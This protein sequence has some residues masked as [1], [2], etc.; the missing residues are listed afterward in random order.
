[1]IPFQCSG[2][3][4]GLQVKDE[5]RGQKVKC[6]GCGRVLRVPEALAAPS[7][8]PEAR[9]AEW[10]TRGGSQA[11]PA[12]LAPESATPATFPPGDGPAPF[13]TSGPGVTRNEEGQDKPAELVEFLAPPQAPDEIG[14][15]GPY[16]VLKVLGAGG[17]GV[18]YKAEDPQLQR[19]VALKA[20]LPSLAVSESARQRFLREARAVAAIK[21]DHIV[22]IY[23]VGQDRG[24]P[25]L[26]MEYLDGEPLDE[27]LQRAPPLAP[28]EVLRIGREAAAGLA[29]AHQRGLVHRDIKPANLWLEAPGGRVK[30]LDF[31]LARAA[32]DN[33]QLTQQGAILGTPAYMAPEQGRGETIDARSD[34]FSLGVV[35]YRLSTG[36][37]PF[38]GADVIATL[39]A[40]VTHD[41]T[42]PARLNPELPGPLSDLVMK[43]LEKEPARR[44][45]SAREVAE[46]LGDME[47]AWARA[48]ERIDATES[49][50]AVAPPRPWT[51]AAGRGPAAPRRRR[52][53]WTA[54][55]A[56]VLGLAA[57]G[58]A[59]FAWPRGGH[60][61]HGPEN[62]PTTAK[63][64][65]PAPARYALAFDGKASYV[66]IPSFN[67][68]GRHPLTLEAW[69]VLDRPATDDALEV[70]MG[71]PEKAGVCINSGP[72]R[73]QF[74]AWFGGYVG[75]G[76]KRPVAR[77]R[78]VHLAGVFDGR[79]EIRFYVDGQLQ[80]RTPV[81][82]KFKPSPMPFA[83]GAN[84]NRGDR[85]VD[86]FLG[87][88]AGVRISKV[89]RYDKDFTPVRRF[90]PDADTIALYQFD[91]G[92]GHVLK[93]C[94]GNGHDGR[95]VGAKWVKAG[96]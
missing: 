76:E 34:L 62:K 15:L 38:Q 5:A 87:R 96:P 28:G 57:A 53:L 35:L 92:R 45:G 67:Y 42:P 86:L 6:P 70:L 1:M 14:R 13:G 46:A 30:I 63:G 68:R 8:K 56:G 9:S 36:R 88:I 73:W 77:R 21:H 3:G 37:Q 71:D 80:A 29:A 74:I 4:K 54:A 95:I 26:A 44:P 32:A 51:G 22:A 79:S 43:L 85:Y 23:Q 48:Q 19:L 94:S 58:I 10:P 27:R 39:M 65:P 20:M 91:E 52:G 61:P 40:V 69:A 24:V 93:D 41:P 17:M 25:Y 50:T 11:G 49:L 84:P 90:E 55:A 81:R 64:T 89:A 59:F 47:R 31:G 18:V 72:G 2:C 75:A 60:E 66:T 78:P 83:L 7:P 16:R 12:R 82:K 33:L